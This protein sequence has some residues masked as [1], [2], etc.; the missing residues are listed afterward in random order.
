MKT[1]K[2]HL[3]KHTLTMFLVDA[4]LISLAWLLSYWLRFNLS[5]PPTHDM[6]NMLK[7]MPIAI[8][9]QVICLQFFNAYRGVWRY[10]S[11]PELVK[12]I[13]AVIAAG[14]FLS[15]FA[16]F[17][18]E[19]YILPRS[20][21]LLFA[22][23]NII[24]LGG[25]RVTYRLLKN[26][27]A[28]T[29]TKKQALIIGAG[30]AAENLIRNLRRDSEQA[31][32]PIGLLDDD[33]KKLGKEIHGVR[34]I[35]N[36]S[37]APKI[38]RQKNADTLLIA[39]PSATSEA[40]QRLV[41]L[42][43]RTELPYRTLPNLSDIATGRAS[44]TTIREVALEDLLGRD[45]IQLDLAILADTIGNKVILVTG[46]GGSIGSELCRQIM[47]LAPKR[48]IIVDNNEYNLYKINLEL[49]KHLDNMLISYQLISVTDKASINRLFQDEKPSIIF[50]AAAYKHVPLLE[51]QASVA[52]QNNL[53]GTEIVANAAI[54]NGAEKFILISTDKAVNPTNIM[55]ASKRAAELIC[56]KLSANEK[57]AFSIVRF[58]NVLGSAGSVVPLF[59]KQIAAGGPV[60][61]THPD[62]TRYFMTIPEACQLIL[63]AASMGENA[64]LFVL[65]MG[66]PI[67]IQYLAEQLIKLSGKRLN[68][69]IKIEHTGLRPGEKLYEELFYNKEKLTKT[70]NNKIFRAKT[71]N[72]DTDAFQAK[73]EWLYDNLKKSQNI[74]LRG[75]LFKLI[76]P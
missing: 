7:L 29:P 63:Q 35:G 21:P 8:I 2:Q 49:S 38:A 24:G 4:I 27:Q 42:C 65:D 50:H 74:Q 60:T 6:A 54:A 17:F 58:G 47:Q 9:T 30:S 68:E 45:P 69:D 41:S 31:Y 16:F 55:G 52:V 12:I 28:K 53:Q 13:K 46:G 25:S 19:K 70:K 34:V 10:T 39:M 33:E 1:S 73:L 15:L 36:T 76:S 23:I 56:Q 14:I 26:H 44:V 66:A 59:K 61:V 40:M 32:A 72:L 43:E 64:D 57:T 48:L 51:K 67:K 71:S 20:I 62:I 22:L 37:Q 75:Q 5:L 11:I 3:L 18:G